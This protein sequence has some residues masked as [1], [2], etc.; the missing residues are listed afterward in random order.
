MGV[1]TITLDHEREATATFVPKDSIRGPLMLE[2]ALLGTNLQTDVRR[3]ENSGRK[4]HHDFVVLHLVKI[5]MANE[6]N[7]WTGKAS[8][9][10]NGET[11]TPTALAAWIKL[12]ETVSGNP[13]D[14]RLVVGRSALADV[15]TDQIEDVIAAII[16][17]RATVSTSRALLI[18][19]SGIDAAGKGFVTSRIAESLEKRGITPAVITV[20]GWLNLP[21]VRFCTRRSGE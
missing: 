7:R 3:G 16:S 8:L 11:D 4:L 1:L 12:S 21:H 17:A 2:L 14:G 9:S 6:G 15:E 20:D 10:I 19:I 13:G 5:D 18:A